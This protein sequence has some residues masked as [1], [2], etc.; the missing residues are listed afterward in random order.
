MAQPQLPKSLNETCIRKRPNAPAS[1]V[2]NTIFQKFKA[3]ELNMSQ[4]IEAI[5]DVVTDLQEVVAAL[6][7]PDA[8]A[9]KKK[10]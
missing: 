10:R 6:Q 5:D 1:D 8:K 2:A 7:K 9:K 4:A 3:N